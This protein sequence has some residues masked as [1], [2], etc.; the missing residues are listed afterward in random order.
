MR[1]VDLMRLAWGAIA[2]H[3]LRSILT[4]IGIAIG[5]TAVI[6][7]TSLGEGVRVFVVSEF[8]QFGTNLIAI[9]PGK[10][11]TTGGNPVAMAGTIRRLTVEDIEPLRRLPQVET[12]MPVAFGNARVE[13]GTRGRAVLV[14][15][16]TSEMPRVWKFKVRQGQFLPPGGCIP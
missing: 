6:L 4:M 13:A 5:I 3:R 7:L 12:V 10:S 16:V 2:G 8:S 9:N 15:G 14:Y 1:D 11:E